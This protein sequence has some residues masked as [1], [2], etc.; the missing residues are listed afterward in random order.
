[1]KEKLYFRSIDDTTCY[2]LE[3]HLEDAKDE[4]L[5]EITLVEAVPDNDNPDYIWCSYHAEVGER[6]GCK[7][8][9]CPHYSS[10]SGR[11]TCKH[12]GN[13]Y[14]HGDEVTFKV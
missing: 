10:K 11:G 7:K 9:V 14:S 6:I 8:A 5:V 2:S 1:M 13:F 12:R 3:S 4:E